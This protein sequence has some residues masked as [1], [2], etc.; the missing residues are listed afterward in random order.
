M[1]NLPAAPTYKSGKESVA[2]VGTTA[3]DEAR[4]GGL[5]FL[6]CLAAEVSPQTRPR[7]TIRAS[8]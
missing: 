1:S 3:T 2:P 5:Q 7:S 8:P 6:G 4:S